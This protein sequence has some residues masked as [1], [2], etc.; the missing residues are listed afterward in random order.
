MVWTCSV[1]GKTGLTFEEAL[2]SE[3]TAK[4]MLNSFPVGLQAPVLFLVK[5]I[6]ES[7]FGEIVNLIYAF[8]ANRYF[9]GEEVLATLNHGKK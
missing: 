1:T 8:I 3:E 7:K 9:I 2:T 5:L 4:S 6:E